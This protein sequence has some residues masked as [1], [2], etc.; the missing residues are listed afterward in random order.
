MAKTSVQF[1]KD[2]CLINL[3]DLAELVT[4]LSQS[5]FLVSLANRKDFG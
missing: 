4:L 3:L 2:V 1:F 5:V